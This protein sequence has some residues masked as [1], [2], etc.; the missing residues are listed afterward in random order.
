MTGDRQVGAGRLFQVIQLS[1]MT[2]L[3]WPERMIPLI[4]L[5]SP[6]KTFSSIPQRMLI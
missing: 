6:F 1:L 3:S 5:V 2:Q 4:Q